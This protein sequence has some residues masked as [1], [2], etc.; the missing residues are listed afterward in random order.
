MPTLALTL[1]VAFAAPVEV[2]PNDLPPNEE[3]QI[4]EAQEQAT[5][6]QQPSAQ[7]VWGVGLLAGGSALLAVTATGAVLVEAV[8]RPDDRDDE[9]AH[10]EVLQVL[11]F[12]TM[13]L[14][15]ASIGAMVAGGALVVSE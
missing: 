4:R 1:V 2:P 6:E 3:T 11:N 12:G 9:I 13:V 10:P 14:G 15:A 7:R 5:Q 8:T